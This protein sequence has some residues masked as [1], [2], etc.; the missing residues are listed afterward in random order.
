MILT[1]KGSEEWTLT[2]KETYNLRQPRR[3]HM[4]NYVV[5]YI[6]EDHDS[7]W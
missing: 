7:G 2:T 3:D 4:D 5:S 1:D 6:E